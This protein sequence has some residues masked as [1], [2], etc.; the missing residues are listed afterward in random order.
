MRD[1]KSGSSK[2][3]SRSTGHLFEGRGMVTLALALARVRLRCRWA[4]AAGLAWP[5]AADLQNSSSTLRTAFSLLG[6]SSGST[7]ADLCLF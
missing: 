3:L 7:S 6:R 1:L 5:E 2:R 4:P